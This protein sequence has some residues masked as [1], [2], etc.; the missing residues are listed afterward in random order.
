MFFMNSTIASYAEKA[1]EIIKLSTSTMIF[2]NS[3][4]W[5][6]NRPW[7]IDIDNQLNNN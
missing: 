6:E 3:I 4:V 7:Q 5:G 1:A 2:V